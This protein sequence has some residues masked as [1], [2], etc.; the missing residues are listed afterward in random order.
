MKRLLP[1]VLFGALLLGSRSLALAQTEG[2]AQPQSERAEGA[3]AEHEE[4][5]WASVF[6]W[7]NFLVL[8]G[9]LGYVLRKPAREFFE[10]RRRDIASGLQRAQEAQAGAQARMAEI[11]QRLSRLSTEVAALRSDAEKES[12]TERDAIVSEAKREVDRVIEQSRQEIERVA[13]SAEREIKE[14]IADMVV[15][16]AGNALRTEMTE[17]D[18]KRVVVRFIKKL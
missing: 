11:E 18:Q 12:L 3:S 6:R 7:A 8:F 14:S 2:A 10:A 4:S 15:N 17:D 1:F 16:R 9:G 5:P 13:R